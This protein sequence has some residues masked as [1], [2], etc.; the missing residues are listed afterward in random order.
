MYADQEWY[1]IYTIYALEKKYVEVMS[2]EVLFQKQNEQNVVWIWF[3]FCSRRRVSTGHNL[4]KPQ[5]FKDVE[6]IGLEK[7]ASSIKVMSKVGWKN[8]V[9]FVQNVLQLK[10]LQMLDT[11]T[12]LSWVLMTYVQWFGE[13]ACVTN[14]PSIVL[15]SKKVVLC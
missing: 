1:M 8:R 3:W 10:K 4:P 5:F 7:T 14:M 12:Y 9:R 15:S 2:H 6:S 13:T 11:L